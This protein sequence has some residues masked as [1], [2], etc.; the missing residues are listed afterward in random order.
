MVK[1]IL[2]IGTQ[3]TGT[4][5]IQNFLYKNANILRDNYNI[6]VPTFLGDSEGWHYWMRSLGNK[7]NHEKLKQNFPPLNKYLLKEKQFELIQ[8]LKQSNMKKVIFS[9]EHMCSS[10]PDDIEKLKVFLENYF[11]DFM[12]I[13]YFRDPLKSAISWWST[14]IKGPFQYDSLESGLPNP[15]K[16]STMWPLF[17]AESILNNW[18]RFFP[19][20]IKVLLFNKSLFSGGNLISDFFNAIDKNTNFQRLES[21]E[22]K[23]E[24]LDWEAIKL[25][26]YLDENCKGISKKVYLP[27]RN[28][29]LFL[30]NDYGINEKGAK[31]KYLPTR[32]EIQQYQKEFKYQNQFISKYSKIPESELLPIEKINPPREDRE[33]NF[34]ALNLNP[35]QTAFAK[36]IIG[37]IKSLNYIP[38]SKIDTFI[39][40]LSEIKTDQKISAT[41]YRHL[42]EVGKSLRPEGAI[43]TR[44]ISVVSNPE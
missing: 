37:I 16:S 42:L 25:I 35:E 6:G 3:K 5:S 2:H 38:P 44:L 19:G 34:Y 8:W 21:V 10:K 1:A 24:T 29:L 14:Q 43:I 17:S 36:L 33:S 27:W 30:L 31:R 20:K 39:K 12:I 23:N 4:T 32:E 40:V 18:N 9:C 7:E 26:S 15:S 11:D 22:V 13:I 41:Q 28:R